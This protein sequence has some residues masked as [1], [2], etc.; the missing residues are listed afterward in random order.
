MKHN[1]RS[2]NPVKDSGGNIYGLPDRV[3]YYVGVFT[4]Y[5][6]LFFAISYFTKKDQVRENEEINAHGVRNNK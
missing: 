6:L 4:F 3:V 1:A 2:H 5:V